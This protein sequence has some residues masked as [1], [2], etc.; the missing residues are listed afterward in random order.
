MI[1]SASEAEWSQLKCNVWEL[2]GSLL[3]YVR[4]KQPHTR[5]T[6]VR[7]YLSKLKQTVK[8]IDHAIIFHYLSQHL[9]KA[10]PILCSK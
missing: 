9:S 5:A 1:N 7:C 3:I 2:F 4:T 6:D 10:L 8:A